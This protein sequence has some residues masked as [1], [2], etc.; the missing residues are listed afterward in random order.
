MRPPLPA[1]RTAPDEL[2]APSRPQTTLDHALATELAALEASGLR[3]TL[4]PLG[5]RHGARL[6][7]GSQVLVDF[8]S[9]DYLALASDPRVAAAATSALE[10]VGT[11]AA[12]ARLI[13]GHHALHTA[14]EEALARFVGTEQ[15]LLF[16]AGYMANLG[17]I[18][19]LV[20]R[21]DAIYADV[22]NHASLIDGAR[23]SRA[24][25]HRIPHAD[26][27]ALDRAL[28]ATGAQYRRRLLVVEGLYSMD[29]DLYPLEELVRI[30]TRYDAWIYLDDAHGFG[31]L[32]AGGRGAAEHWG[33][34]GD[35]PIRVGTL[36]KAMGTAGAFVAGSATLIEFLMNRARSF[37]FTTG[38]PPA[39]AAATHAALEI[40]AR[41]P[42]R[43][44][45]VR[46]NA[47]RLRAGLAA[48]GRV[49]PGPPDAHIVPILTGT[50]GAVMPAGT[51][52]RAKGFLV[53]AVR[54][55]S[56]C[57]SGVGACAS[58]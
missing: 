5:N 46:A 18:P 24:E 6:R 17:V 20:G 21:H 22:Q 3:R 12:A 23:L 14:L 13:A 27:A 2:L 52:R 26:P 19:A 15:A 54:P 9:N 58:P 50:S 11:G 36:G 49:M 35:V 1:P 40:A 44:D 37:V 38:T 10:Q 56:G 4:H 33:V 31:V 7:D 29:G 42:E 30:A 47:R 53:G 45:R 34:E 41:E 16:P 28:G 43:R 51:A 32:G 55:P 8:A 48:L 25:V 57:P 39:L